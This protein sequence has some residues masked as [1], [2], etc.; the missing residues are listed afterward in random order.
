MMASCCAVAREDYLRLVDMETPN[1][2]RTDNFGGGMWVT[3]W[4]VGKGGEGLSE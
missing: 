2:C 1:S 4:A 3:P